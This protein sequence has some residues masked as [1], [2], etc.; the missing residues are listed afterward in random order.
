MKHFFVI[1]PHS[2]RSQ[3]S[4]NNIIADIDYSFSYDPG[5]NYDIYLSRYPRDAISAIH[6]Y[7]SNCNCDELVRI[8]AVGGD[9][10][11]FDC[12]NGMVNFPN[13]EL[14]CVP[15]GNDNDFIRAFGD[16]VYDRFR[17]LKKLSVS[18]SRPVDIIHCGSNYAMI[19]THIGF[20]GHSV[21]I[22]SEMFRRIPEKI[23][24][25]N[26][27]NAYLICV[28]KAL[29]NNEVMRQYYT[30][31]VDG[32]EL[33]GNYCNIHIANSACTGGSM[34]LSPYARADN[35]SMEVIFIKTNRKRDILR[36]MSDYTK[37]HFEKHD[38]F[39]RRRCKKIVVK[40]ETVMCVQMDGEAF[41][42]RELSMELIPGC[43][44]FFSPEDLD[45]IDY[46]NK[47]YNNDEKRKLKTNEKK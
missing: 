18:P 47:A 25:N 34:L 26:V 11:L 5:I 43:I 28:L 46:S 41:H 31:F 32:E 38:I 14:T 24:R 13:A 39:I 23:L 6:R 12:L 36:L 42:S 9:G 30:I 35:G 45:I 10:I 1:N 22:A 2:F 8:Y 15:Y 33:S 17:D 40:S 19:E 27:S 7:I 21:I 20:V 37:G 29:F 44:K 16:K 3:G 4:L